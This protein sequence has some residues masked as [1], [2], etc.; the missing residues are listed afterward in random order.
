[1]RISNAMMAEVDSWASRQ[2]DR[3]GRSEAVRRLLELGLC[4]DRL[5]ELDY[6]A[7]KLLAMDR[8]PPQTPPAPA[9]KE[10]SIHENDQAE[11]PKF[12]ASRLEAHSEAALMNYRDFEIETFELEH[13]QWHARC[14]RADHRPTLIDGVEL[15]F[16]D[17]GI[18]WPTIEAAMADAQK[19]LDRMT[20]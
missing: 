9:D 15:D 17:T 3:P 13:G 5:H 11:Q 19:Y 4:L 7:T 2:D 12:I 1:M 20:A 16:L 8:Q 10:P 18:A 6:M 14:R